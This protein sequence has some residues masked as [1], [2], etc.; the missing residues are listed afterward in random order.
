ME[1][2]QQLP[3]SGW[4]PNP[5]GEGERY[6]DGARWTDQYRAPPPDQ[7]AQ[8]PQEPQSPQAVP[9]QQ[10]PPPQT[11]WWARLT[12]GQKLLLGIGV[13]VLG[14]LLLYNTNPGKRVLAELGI[15]ECYENTLTGDIICGEGAERI[16]RFK[17]N[18]KEQLSDLDRELEADSA[19]AG[20]GI[21]TNNV[22]YST[23]LG[24]TVKVRTTGFLKAN[25]AKVCSVME[26][27]GF[28]PARVVDRKTGLSQNC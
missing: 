12:G 27:E 25:P 7:L 19:L 10:T 17:K 28:M 22:T 14:W 18:T 8:A 6:W 15:E 21:L 23:G 26:A 9:E 20:R 1:S 5:Q 24:Y 4:Y 3:P 11:G 13:A 16:D 2:G